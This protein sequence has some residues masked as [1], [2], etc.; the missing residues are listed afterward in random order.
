MVSRATTVS[1][2][3]IIV[4]AEVFSPRTTGVGEVIVGVGE[5]LVEVLSE[6]EE[7]NI[8]ENNIIKNFMVYFIRTKAL[9][10]P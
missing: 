5:I 9:G 1:S 7:R 10:T 8:K 6:Q 2:L 4:V 3:F